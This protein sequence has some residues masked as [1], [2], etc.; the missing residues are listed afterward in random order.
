M[1][2]KNKK[3]RDKDKY[4]DKDKDTAEGV[5]HNFSHHQHGLLLSDRILQNHHGAS[6]IM[7]MICI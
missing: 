7:M 6:F 4:N 1:G 2:N 3:D 5:E